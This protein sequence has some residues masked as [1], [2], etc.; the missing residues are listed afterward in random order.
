MPKA[1]ETL[2]AG[3]ENMTAQLLGGCLPYRQRNRSMRAAS[4]IPK[5]IA[6]QF[7]RCYVEG[8]LGVGDIG[9][10]INGMQNYPDV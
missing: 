10:V 4:L 2:D 9:K 3:S 6:S 5:P 7:L 8:D 1:T